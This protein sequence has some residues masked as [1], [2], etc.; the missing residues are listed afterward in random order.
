MPGI[1]CWDVCCKGACM[2]HAVPYSGTRIPGHP[3]EQLP[4]DGPPLA[5]L[6]RR[7]NGTTTEHKH[8]CAQRLQETRD[9]WSEPF[10]HVALELSLSLSRSTIW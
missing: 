3:G 9:E 8:W 5:P 4:S 2:A 1:Q 7:W 10:L 6:P